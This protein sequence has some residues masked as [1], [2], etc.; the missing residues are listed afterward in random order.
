MVERSLNRD[1][2]S[3]D[4]AIDVA[5]AVALAALKEFPGGKIVAAAL[6]ET[7]KQIE[8]SGDGSATVSTTQILE[9]MGKLPPD[10][11]E[12]LILEAIDRIGPQTTP[13]ERTVAKAILLP[14][15]SKWEDVAKTIELGKTRSMQVAGELEALELAAA[16][17]G[18]RKAPEY[19]RLESQVE[20]GA[21]EEAHATIDRL[22]DLGASSAELE[23][24]DR[25]ISR[26][27]DWRWITFGAASHIFFMVIAVVSGTHKVPDG[28]YL[29]TI[30]AI[31]L[32]LAFT[33]RRIL[34]R[35]LSKSVRADR[36]RLIWLAV[37][38]WVVTII[39]MIVFK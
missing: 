17:G 24:T 20:A 22:I 5:A 3:W 33:G 15:Q 26:R 12:A 30:L 32:P 39:V 38:A 7:K 14:S 21:W 18:D 4:A 8:K 25:A 6:E 31:G 2:R 11:Y 28:W 10:R 36:R 34:N 23:S 27:R 29:P 16:A 9:W 19:K 35:V 13:G 1:D 37:A